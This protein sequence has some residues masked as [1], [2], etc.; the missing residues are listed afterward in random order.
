MWSDVAKFINLY[1]KKVYKEVQPNINI[2]VSRFFS[3]KLFTIFQN[4]S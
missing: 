2:V 1:M 3:Y 4:L